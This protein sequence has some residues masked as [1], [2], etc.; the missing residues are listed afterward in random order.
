M[1]EDDEEDEVLRWYLV[2]GIW[3]R[4]T[5]K[6]KYYLKKASARMEMAKGRRT[7]GGEMLRTMKMSNVVARMVREL[8]VHDEFIQ[9]Q[10]QSYHHL[11]M[12]FTVEEIYGYVPLSEDETISV[13]LFMICAGRASDELY[14]V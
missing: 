10:M 4:M 3:T 5:R 2:T 14:K 1:D 7:E 9:K 6:M 8:A 12:P 13:E 11:Q